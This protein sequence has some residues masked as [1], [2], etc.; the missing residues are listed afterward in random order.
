MGDRQLTHLMLGL[1]LAVKSCFE[2]MPMRCLP[3]NSVCVCACECYKWRG[4][5]H[6][7]GKNQS[8]CQPLNTFGLLY[9]LSQTINV[10]VYVCLLLFRQP[11]CLSVLQSDCCAFLFCPPLWSHMSLLS[12]LNLLSI[13]NL[14]AITQVL[15]NDTIYLPF[16]Y[17]TVSLYSYFQL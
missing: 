13:L 14:S 12:L 1:R 4:F 9:H 6:C 2:C 11:L 7:R 10:C 15:K 5:S 8:A 17:H 3:K 16:C